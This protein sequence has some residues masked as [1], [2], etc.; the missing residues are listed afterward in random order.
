M[1]IA[2]CGEAPK[3]SQV[4][5]W[6]ARLRNWYPTAQRCKR[7]GRAAESLFRNPH[8]PTRISSIHD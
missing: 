7:V 2:V 5:A 1:R 4:L 3:R 6:A 8:L